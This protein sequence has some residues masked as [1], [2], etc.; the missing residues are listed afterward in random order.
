VPDAIDAERREG[1][2][3]NHDQYASEAMNAFLRGKG[4]AV[5]SISELRGFAFGTRRTVQSGPPLR[6]GEW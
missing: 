6:R 1:F 5:L 4:N 2:Q 3:A